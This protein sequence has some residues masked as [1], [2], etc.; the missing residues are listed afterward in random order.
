MTLL[1]IA[2][3]TSAAAKNLAQQ[4]QTLNLLDL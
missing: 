3:D 2:T 1:Q 4:P